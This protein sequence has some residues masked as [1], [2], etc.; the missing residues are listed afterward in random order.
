MRTLFALHYLEQCV[1]HTLG[2]LIYRYID[3][4][5]FALFEVMQTWHVSSMGLSGRR[6]DGLWLMCNT[7][8]DVY[9]YHCS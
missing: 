5:H 1:E 9:H 7:V 4:G 2:L 3:V 6:H 8:G